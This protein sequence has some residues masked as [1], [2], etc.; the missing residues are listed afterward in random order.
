MRKYI[1][2]PYSYFELAK[3]DFSQPFVQKGENKADVCDRFVIGGLYEL[4]K[5][6]KD[7][8]Y[9][10]PHNLRCKKEFLEKFF[11]KYKNNYNFIEG[12]NVYIRPSTYDAEQYLLLPFMGLSIEKT[13][14][15]IKIINDFFAIVRTI[16]GK[17]SVP[18]KFS[19]LCHVGVEDFE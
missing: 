15:I 3:I 8:Y 16:D 9:F 18:I 4:V 6:E 11:L 10:E 14:Q 7:F 13:T 17:E 12:E 19:D 2:S 5:E 1:Y